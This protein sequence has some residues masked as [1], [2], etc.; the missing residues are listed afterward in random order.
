MTGHL[1]YGWTAYTPT[2]TLRRERYPTGRGFIRRPRKQFFYPGPINPWT[3]DA[4]LSAIRRPWAPTAHGDSESAQMHNYPLK[5][6]SIVP[7]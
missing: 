1:N 5:S 4:A 7:E 6:H 3:V 2:P